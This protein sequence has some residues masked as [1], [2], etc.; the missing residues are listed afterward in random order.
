M[1]AFVRVAYIVKT[2]NLEGSVVAQSADGLPF[3]L[4]EGLQVH[5]VPPTLRGPRTAKVRTVRALGEDAY[6]VSFDGVEGIGDAEMLA[7]CYCLASKADVEGQVDLQEPV[8]LIGCG[9]SDA[10]FGDLGIVEDVLESPAQALL[11]VQ[12]SHGR[13]MIPVVDEFM[14]GLDEGSRTVCVRIPDGL[15]S[16]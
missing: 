8:T 5:F 10:R 4:F 14:E 13:V 11:V 15:L 1:S 2:K 12:G 16:L 6:E 7:G 3:L 9:V